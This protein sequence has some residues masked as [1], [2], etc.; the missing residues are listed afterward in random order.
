MFQRFV[1]GGHNLNA[2]FE[3]EA[4][5][6]GT[7]YFSTFYI[8]LQGENIVNYAIQH[9]PHLNRVLFV[10]DTNHILKK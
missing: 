9:R 2:V 5:I 1:S 4:K 10:K 3:L 7:T 8:Q 6:C